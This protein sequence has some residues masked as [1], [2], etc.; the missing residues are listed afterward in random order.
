MSRAFK[1]LALLSLAITA[2]VPGA[3]LAQ[4]EDEADAS[5]EPTIIVTADALPETAGARAFSVNEVG[6]DAI[7]AEVS[8]RLEG[9]LQTVPG[10]QQFRRSDSRSSNPTAQGVTLRGL[11]GNASSRA[12]VTLDGVPVIDPFF[13]NVPFG[14]LPAEA[15]GSIRVRRGGATGA[16]GSGAL[17]GA[18]ALQSLVPGDSEPFLASALVN[19]RGETELAGLANIALPG[20]VS[21]LAGGRWDRGQGFFTARPEE[22]VA[23]SARARFDAASGFARAVI[24]VARD[25]SVQASARA[26]DDNRTLR[27]DG[28][29]SRASGQDISFRALHDGGADGWAAEVLGYYQWRD[30]SNVVV[31][32][33]RFVPVLD[34]RE[35]PSTGA[36]GKLE[37]RPPLGEAMD[38][39]LGA[40]LRVSD[41]RI[42]EDRFSAFSGAMTGRRFSGGR[43]RDAGLFAQADYRRGALLITGGLRGDFWTISQG[44]FREEDAS[45]GALTNDRFKARKGADTSFNAGAALEAAPGLTLRAGGYGALRLPTL[46]E[47][48]RPFVIFPVTTLANAGLEPERLRGVEAGLDWQV[49]DNARD[50]LSVSLTAFDNRVEGAIANVTLDATTRQR[51][52]LDAVR[53]RGVELVASGRS[54]AFFAD[55]SAAFA[56]ARIEASGA[57][58][59]QDG[60]R[61]P[62]VPRFSAFARIGWQD[63]DGTRAALDL[64][65]V[66]DQFEDEAGALPLPAYT[67]I[68]LFASIRFSGGLSA[69]LRAENLADVDV[70]TRDTG[71]S[72]DL[73]VPRTIWAGLRYGF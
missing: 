71:D 33:T 59:A 44:F 55:V 45:G 47:L 15:I 64:R 21:L 60:E 46:N 10:F 14:A 41:G 53:A 30:F 65:H 69:I 42:A 17:T 25:T 16:F 51:R 38:I 3:A 5:G 52:N 67:L 56:D 29:D 39:A 50:A 37:V 11:G 54:G 72:R 12:L 48:Y 9:A 57:A 43:V 2:P 24:P 73:G 70:I 62:Q 13:G 58:L 34:Q 6:R 26:F 4:G 28:A 36:G 40:D 1:P 63:G 23:A 22:R 7:T 8:G 49:A 20:G 32:S 66:G 19:Q 61:P 68:G 18:I 35:T 27:F 31:S